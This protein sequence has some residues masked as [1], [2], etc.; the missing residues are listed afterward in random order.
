VTHLVNRFLH[1][2]LEEELLVG[3]LPIKLRVQSKQ[4][5]QRDS[6]WR[7]SLAEDKVE[8][9]NIQVKCGHT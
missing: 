9:M 2:T 8:T 7:M 5:Y 4:R 6:A 1:C 3:R